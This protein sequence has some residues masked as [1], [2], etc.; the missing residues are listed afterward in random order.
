MKEYLKLAANDYECRMDLIKGL[1]EHN[2]LF[3]VVKQLR[4]IKGMRLSYISKISLKRDLYFND[5]D[6]VVSGLYKNSRIGIGYLKID[7]FPD[8]LE[9]Y[10]NISDISGA[11]KLKNGQRIKAVV[12]LNGFGL[13]VI[14]IL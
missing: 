9:A 5:G 8:M 13:Y 1:I 10:I 14:N 11:V 4:I 2:A 6:Y 7:G 3:E 12:G